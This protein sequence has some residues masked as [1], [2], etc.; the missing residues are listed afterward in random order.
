MCAPIPAAS[1]PEPERASSSHSTASATQSASVAVLQPEPAARGELR[2]DLVGEAARRLPLGCVR[3]QLALD[4]R[5]HLRP[6]RLVALRERR[7]RPHSRLRSIPN[8][9]RSTLRWSRWPC[10]RAQEVADV[11]RS[12]RRGAALAAAALGT[13]TC[14]ISVGGSGAG[15][16]QPL[17]EDLARARGCRAARRSARTAATP[18]RRPRRRAPGPCS[19]PAPPAACGRP[20]SGC[21]GPTA[22]SPTASPIPIWVSSSSRS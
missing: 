15:C 3:A 2:E 6:Q 5:P 18:W 11:G 12:R 22:P 16:R 7:D 10:A 4:E 19:R 1:P 20:G 8:T 9:P 13:G 21:R 14:S 17:R